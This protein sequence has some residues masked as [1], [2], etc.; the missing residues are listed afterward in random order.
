MQ[1]SLKACGFIVGIIL[2]VGYSMTEAEAN[3]EAESPTFELDTMTHILD[4]D[5]DGMPNGWEVTFGTNPL[6]ADA[7]TDSD[8]DGIN[9]LSEYNAGTNPL[10]DDWKGPSAFAS[11]SFLAD[12]GGFN[13][14][15]SPDTDGDGMPNWWE[16]KYGSSAESMGGLGFG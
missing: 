15:Y 9:N 11:A 10:V 8:G 5:G 1:K 13:G 7:L 6:V 2:N 3:L 16:I 12:T 4:G 14:G